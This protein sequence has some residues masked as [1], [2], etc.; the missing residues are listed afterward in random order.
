MVGS[1]IK[2]F[3]YV[4]NVYPK[5]TDKN[6]QLILEYQQERF[7]REFGQDLHSFM[8]MDEAEFETMFLTMY[9]CYLR[10]KIS[11]SIRFILPDM[12][13]AK[14]KKEFACLDDGFVEALEYILR[15][16]KKYISEIIQTRNKYLFQFVDSETH[17]EL[18]PSD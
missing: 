15:I 3:L 14:F 16:P 4:S 2:N 18:T 12:D 10:Q 11:G 6:L 7:K 17:V 5:I 9:E 1:L 8:Q 13:R